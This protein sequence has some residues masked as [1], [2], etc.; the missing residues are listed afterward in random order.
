MKLNGIELPQLPEG[1]E[2]KSDTERESVGVRKGGIYLVCMDTVGYSRFRRP[3]GGETVA[4]ILFGGAW[5]VGNLGEPL[6]EFNVAS[7]F[8]EGVNLALQHVLLGIWV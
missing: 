3:S 7:S 2:W 4:R 1:Y 6:G 8:E 5:A